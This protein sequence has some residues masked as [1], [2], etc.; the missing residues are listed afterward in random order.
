[1][2]NVTKIHDHVLA[3]RRS[4]MREIAETVGISKDCVDHIVHEVL[5]MRELSER[6]VPHLLTL[7][8]K[9]NRESISEQ[10][11]T[12]FKHNPE[13]FL[14]RFE[15]VD[16]TRIHWYTPEIRKSQNSRL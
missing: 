3:D 7:A 13:K 14:R 9:R 11:L 8:N 15:T 5:G 12:K 2:V 6:W 1:M 16:E 10:G 4:K